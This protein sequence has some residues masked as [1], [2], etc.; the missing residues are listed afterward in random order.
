MEIVSM[1]LDFLEQ[2]SF[3][4]KISPKNLAIMSNLAKQHFYK[5]GTLI[6]NY[7]QS[8]TTFLYLIKG[9]VKLFKESSDGKEVIVDILNNDHYCGEQFFFKKNED[10][11]ELYKAQSISDVEVFTM[12]IS[13]LYQL[14]L[15]DS[16]LSA[17]LLQDILRKQQ[18]LNMEVE[19]LSIQNSAQRIGCFL[20]RLYALQGEEKVTFRLPFDKGLLASRLSMGPET[21]SRAFNKF[22]KECDVSMDGNVIHIN[23]VN[24]VT[25]YVCEHCT[26]VFPCK[27]TIN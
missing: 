23:N 7:D 12:S 24:S 10:E 22:T 16:H 4:S 14:V 5:K 8:S 9:W 11:N 15:S 27:E 1:A 3:F 17:S 25:H 21:F 19:H 18:H 13:S 6:L 2:C 26:K 20:L